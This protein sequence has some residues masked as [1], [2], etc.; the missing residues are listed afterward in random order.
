MADITI[1]GISCSHQSI[2]TAGWRGPNPFK[3]WFGSILPALAKHCGSRCGRHCLN[4]GT[5]LY[6]SKT[7]YHLKTSKAEVMLRFYWAVE[8]IILLCLTPSDTACL[9]VPTAFGPMLYIYHCTR[10]TQV[11]SISLTQL[12]PLLPCRQ[13]I[14]PPCYLFKFYVAPSQRVRKIVPWEKD[15]NNLWQCTWVKCPEV[16]KQLQAVTDGPCCKLSAAP[17]TETPN[18][19]M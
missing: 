5:Q 18:R 16:M 4:G 11:H 13:P 17:V 9:W 15:N 3:R 8:H 2:A 12:F 10:S 14:Y 7:K 6:C 1:K 19:Q